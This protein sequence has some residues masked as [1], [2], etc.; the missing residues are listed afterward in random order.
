MPTMLHVRFGP[1]DVGTRGG[2][3]A[4]TTPGA[5]EG[6]VPAPALCGQLLVQH[7]EHDAAGEG[8]LERD[9]HRVENR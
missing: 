4:Y 9:L 7:V 2:K 6:P 5:D 3:F 8:G 1:P